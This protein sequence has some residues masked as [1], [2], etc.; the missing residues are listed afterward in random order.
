MYYSITNFLVR[1]KVGV[2]LEALPWI[3]EFMGKIFILKY[4]GELL[5]DNINLKNIALDICFLSSVGIRCI[6]VHGGQQ[7]LDKKLKDENINY[8]KKNGLRVYNK[9]ILDIAR[10]V[11]KGI[12]ENL[13]DALGEENVKPFL[14]DESAISAEKIEG[15]GFVGNITEIDKDLLKQKIRKKIVP[16]VSPLGMF[17]D[18][19]LLGINADAVAAY[20]AE[21]LNA[22]KM[23]IITSVEGVND[24]NNKVI[25]ELT[26]QHAKELIANEVITKGMVTKV[27][28]CIDSQKVKKVH[29][30]DGSKPH[31][32]LY[33]VF[34][35]RGFGTEITRK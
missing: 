18:K 2:L 31:T 14:I 15:L 24:I 10:D 22:E 20:I 1:K 17:N 26:S 9:E 7:Q 11:F 35:D 6:I 4:S 33:E 30:I 21:E 13:A 28:H 32:I 12:S 8:M 5:E 19:S 29:I 16:I 27:L 23:I 3:R 34:T 25:H